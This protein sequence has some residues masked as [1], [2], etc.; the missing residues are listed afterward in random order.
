M[1][2]LAF[3]VTGLQAAT[4]GLAPLLHFT[5]KITNQPGTELIHTVLLH[6]QV[7]IEAPGRSYNGNEKEKLV[8][9]F[10]TP[11]RWGQTLRNRLLGLS[12]TTVRAFSGTAET[13]L[14]LPC[15]FDLNLAATKYFNALDGGEVPLLFLFSGSIFYEG[16]DGRL[17]VQQIS[18]NKECKYKMPVQTWRDT[19]EEH[20]PNTSYLYLQREV[21]ERLYA[22]KRQNGFPTW[23]ATVNALLETQPKAEVTP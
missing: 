3:E 13:T 7:Q 17:Q 11:E 23:E 15:S 10:G 18:W 6:A 5:V 22:Y 16:A 1:P 20:F 12:V 21:F 14:S 8:E 4:R 2:D 19:M 9:L